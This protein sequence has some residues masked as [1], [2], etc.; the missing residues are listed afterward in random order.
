M[1]WRVASDIF[2]LLGLSVSLF[3]LPLPFLPISCEVLLFRE[4]DLPLRGRDIL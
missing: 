1:R 4:G 3:L 2:G